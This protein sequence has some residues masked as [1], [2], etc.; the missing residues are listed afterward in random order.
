MKIESGQRGFDKRRDATGHDLGGK[1]TD[2]SADLILSLVV[3]DGAWARSQ[4]RRR[5]QAYV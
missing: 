4:I 5:E 3:L 2:D 1:L